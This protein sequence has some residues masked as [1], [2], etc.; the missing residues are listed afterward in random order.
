METADGFVQTCKLELN[1]TDNSIK[2]TPFNINYQKQNSTVSDIQIS[3]EFLNAALVDIALSA[4]EGLNFYST[5][6]NTTEEDFQNIFWFDNQLRL[7]LPYF[8]TFLL[9]LPFV[10]I[11]MIR[12]WRNRDEAPVGSEKLQS[13]AKDVCYTFGLSEMAAQERLKHLKLRYGEM[14]SESG[15]RR[16]WFETEKE[17]RGLKRRNISAVAVW[18]RKIRKRRDA[19]HRYQMSHKSPTTTM[20]AKV[21]TRAIILAGLAHAAPAPQNNDCTQ[22][23]YR[24]SLLGIEIEIC[25]VDGWKTASTCGGPTCRYNNDLPTPVPYCHDP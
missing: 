5:S 6:V 3:K 19:K 18:F 23:L 25:S 10:I 20:F 9:A 2:H 12:L 14:N 8:L 21:I 1:S 22:G 15:K 7:V 13:A 16:A 17:T 4:V 11:G 24:C